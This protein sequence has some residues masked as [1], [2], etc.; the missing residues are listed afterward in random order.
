MIA[1]VEVEAARALSIAP[2]GRGTPI[3]AVAAGIA[4]RRPVPPAGGGKEYRV[5][6]LSARKPAAYSV[7]VYLNNKDSV[8]M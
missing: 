8:L 2:E 6:V 4:E 7:S 3:V 1:T 5:A